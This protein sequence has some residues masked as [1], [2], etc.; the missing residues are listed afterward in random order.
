M[1][2]LKKCAFCGGGDIVKSCVALDYPTQ[3]VK[4]Y[5]SC[6]NC[7]AEISQRG[8]VKDSKTL[9]NAAIKTWN[10]RNGEDSEDDQ[11]Q[12]CHN[13]LQCLAWSQEGFKTRCNR[14]NYFKKHYANGNKKIIGAEILAELDQ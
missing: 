13:A 3:N 8:N 5:V 6:S 7:N 4:A 11:C 12:P 9:L 14:W 1:G 2:K 10:S